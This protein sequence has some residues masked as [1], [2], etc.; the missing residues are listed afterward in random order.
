MRAPGRNY[1]CMSELGYQQWNTPAFSTNVAQNA[2]HSRLPGSPISRAC[3]F[4]CRGCRGGQ[5]DGPLCA[6]PAHQ[7]VRAGPGALR[8][9]R[10]VA[11]D[12]RLSRPAWNCRESH[13]RPARPRT[14][15]PG[16]PRRRSDMDEPRCGSANARTLHGA[17]LSGLHADKSSVGN[18]TCTAQH[19]PRSA[20]QLA[21]SMRS[22]DM[23]LSA[24]LLSSRS[25]RSSWRLL[26]WMVVLCWWYLGF[27]S[28]GWRRT[29]WRRR[30]PAQQAHADEQLWRPLPSPQ[31]PA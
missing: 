6:A 18:S 28:A 15:L 29:P 20:Q 7:P 8:H 1:V 14:E 12:A 23:R 17:A 30:Q 2:L 24:A 22:A 4:L 13:Q 26:S 25:A 9:C 11:P 5:Q 16:Y 10:C 3:G 31:A 19:T 27:I 21:G